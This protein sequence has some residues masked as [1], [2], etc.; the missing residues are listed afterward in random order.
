MAICIHNNYDCIGDHKLTTYF[1]E[2]M[3]TMENMSVTDGQNN[4]KSGLKPY[5]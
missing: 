5:N 3:E 1:Q 2:Y 4:A